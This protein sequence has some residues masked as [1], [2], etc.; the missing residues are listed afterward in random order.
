MTGSAGHP[1]VHIFRLTIVT[2]GEGH[3][4]VRQQLPARPGEPVPAGVVMWDFDG[5]LAFR[6]GMWRG[7]LIEALDVVRP[8]HSIG[9]DD[10]RPWLRDGFPWHRP[11]EGHPHLDTAE[12]WWQS[13][14]PL[15]EEAYRRAGV[16]ARAA[17]AAAALVRRHYTDPGRWAIFADTRPAL[18]SLTAAGWRHII[19]SNHVPELPT[20]VQALGLD[21][22]IATVVTSAQTGYEKPHPHM[23]AIALERA[24]D[25][26][27]VWMVGDN[28]AAD[29]QGAQAAGIPSILVRT[30]A[31]K[32]DLPLSLHDAAE[33]IARSQPV[34]ERA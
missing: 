16:S 11:G 23:F 32:H 28:P 6:E 33:L 13:L 15:F 8:G 31:G 3:R 24:G 12:A 9:M 26:A 1:G 29:I 14:T 18:T 4:A 34:H 10:V 25:P 21:D 30:A 5:T 17:A 20:L 19:V 22:L 27:R 2:V 7:C